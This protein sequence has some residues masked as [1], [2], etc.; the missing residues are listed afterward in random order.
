MEEFKGWY[1]STNLTLKNYKDFCNGSRNGHL[2]LPKN[3]S[4]D[5]DPIEEWWLN[6]GGHLY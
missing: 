2:G 1:E 4:L 6:T 5:S 3:T